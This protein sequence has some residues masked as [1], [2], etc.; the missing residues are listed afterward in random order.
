MDIIRTSVFTI[1]LLIWRATTTTVPLIAVRMLNNQDYNSFIS[2]LGIIQIGAG[3]VGFGQVQYSYRRGSIESKSNEM[4][5]ATSVTISISIFLFGF[6]TLIPLGQTNIHAGLAAALTLAAISLFLVDFT[7]TNALISG[8]HVNAAKIL[9]S[10]AFFYACATLLW[11]KMKNPYWILTGC[12]SAAIFILIPNI[13][14]PGGVM[15]RDGARHLLRRLKFGGAQTVILICTGSLPVFMNLL[16]PYSNTD[17]VGSKFISTFTAVCGGCLFFMTSRL[18]SK[19]AIIANTRYEDAWHNVAIFIRR[20]AF[21]T[22]PVIP[23][24][25]FIA[26]YL[27]S[28]TNILFGVI[29]WFFILAQLTVIYCRYVCFGNELLHIDLIANLLPSASVYLAIVLLSITKVK[30]E[31][32]YFLSLIAVLPLGSAVIYMSKL[33]AFKS[34]TVYE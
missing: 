5:Y 32:I 14:N 13:F 25:Q 26:M 3:I 15:T 19:S 2:L 21:F 29:A 33:R 9:I 17:I 16:M 23:I 11:L 8:R 34:K 18:T 28:F 1:A 31:P 7:S 22:L 4:L 20:S 24:A 30:I 10:A 6:L 12:I 27:L